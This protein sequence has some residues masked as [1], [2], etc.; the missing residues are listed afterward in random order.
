MKRCDNL[1]HYFEQIISMPFFNASLQFKNFKFLDYNIPIPI[2]LL[3][4]MGGNFNS[5]VNNKA[6][7]YLFN[8]LLEKNLL[9]VDDFENFPEIYTNLSKFKPLSFEDHLYKT[10]IYQLLDFF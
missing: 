8:F 9:M 1:F 10:F 6:E 3:E 5:W 2:N 4:V 7:E